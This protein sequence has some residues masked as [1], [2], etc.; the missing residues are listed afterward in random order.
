M[1]AKYADYILFQTGWSSAGAA[2]R[3]ESCAVIYLITYIPPCSTSETY[4][5]PCILSCAAVP[6]WHL[7]LST[8]AGQDDGVI[9]S[10]GSA[11]AFQVP[12]P[13]TPGIYYMGPML[14][15]EAQ[16]LRPLMTG[17]FPYV[18]MLGNTDLEPSTTVG[19]WLDLGSQSTREGSNGGST[20]LVNVRLTRTKLARQTLFSMDGVHAVY[21]QADGSDVWTYRYKTSCS[22]T[23]ILYNFTIP[24]DQFTVFGIRVTASGVDIWQPSSGL[25]AAVQT[26]LCPDAWIYSETLIGRAASDLVAQVGPTLSWPYASFD[27]KDVI[28]YDW[29]M[30]N[31]E[32]VSKAQELLTKVYNVPW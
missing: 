8:L 26:P 15:R 13:S 5:K 16:S 27:I 3:P 25:Q 29:P 1:F 17:P 21:R 9:S 11:T 18:G 12:D 30:S 32:L 20:I 28:W 14:Y 2:A 19:T 22:S 23:T 4:A 7:D 24:H 6:T 31:A 10:W